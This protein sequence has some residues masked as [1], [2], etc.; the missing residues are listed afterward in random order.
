MFSTV[1]SGGLCGM[2]TYRVSVEVDISTGLPIFNMVGL[3]SGEVRE[4]KERVLVALK[5]T[6]YDLPPRKITVNLAPADRRKEGNGYDL[7]IALGIL[8]SLG[9]FEKEALESVFV[10]GELGLNGEIKPVRGILPMVKKA[11]EEGMRECII[12]KDNAKEGAVIP[13]ICVRGA[14]T[15]AQVVA[16]LQNKEEAGLTRECVDVDALFQKERQEET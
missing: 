4:A 8:E 2:E 1:I 12:P 15:L 9:Y 13:G 7:P 3:L 11:E 10:T 16:F 14:Q 5:N 6:G